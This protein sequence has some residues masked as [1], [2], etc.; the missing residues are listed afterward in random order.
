MGNDY[1]YDVVAEATKVSEYN[2]GCHNHTLKSN[3]W[4]C[5]VG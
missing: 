1:E 2:L 4:H 5:E 3:Q